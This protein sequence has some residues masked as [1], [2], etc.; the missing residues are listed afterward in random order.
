MCT[1]Q[2]HNEQRTEEWRNRFFFFFAAAAAAEKVATFWV[3]IDLPSKW[4]YSG[5]FVGNQGIFV[6]ESVS[7]SIVAIQIGFAKSFVDKLYTIQ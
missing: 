1:P 6:M 4:F 2:N 3:T 5:I 7:P